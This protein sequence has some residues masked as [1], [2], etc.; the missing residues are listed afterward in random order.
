MIMRLAVLLL[1]VAATV[2]WAA[3]PTPFA[4]AMRGP[5]PI[6]DSTNPPDLPGG[7]ENKDIRR[8]RAYP[9]Q[10]PTIPHRVDGY[11]IDRNV[12]KCL[13]CH[14]R[15]KTEQTQAI[16]VSVTHYMDRGGNVLADI[17]PRRYF[18]DQCHVAQM[19][20]KPLVANTFQ[21]VDTV[22]KDAA[23][24]APAKKK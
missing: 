18:C 2:S 1:F 19:D 7:A 10:P 8:T 15:A 24:K 20:V 12:N 9:M 16:P 3:P 13:T 14:A 11:Q 17:S 5:V 6:A 4:D 21:D 22:L 23:A